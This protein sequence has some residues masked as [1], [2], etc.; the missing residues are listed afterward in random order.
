[1]GFLYSD[2]LTQIMKEKAST[3]KGRTDII[4]AMDPTKNYSVGQ[5]LWS[6]LQV[7][8][9]PLVASLPEHAHL[10]AEHGCY[11]YGKGGECGIAGNR[12]VDSVLPDSFKPLKL[13]DDMDKEWSELIK[14]L[15]L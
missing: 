8:I 11:A 1:M 9:N 10:M 4:P 6:T 12:E 2:E 14:D 13:T 3:D 15:K 7:Y 5:H